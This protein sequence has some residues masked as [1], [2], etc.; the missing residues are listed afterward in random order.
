M[1][2]MCAVL[3]CVSIIATLSLAS[4]QSNSLLWKETNP[5]K[6]VGGALCYILNNWNNCPQKPA[7]SCATIPCTQ[8]IIGLWS[9]DKTTRDVRGIAGW[10]AGAGQV[11]GGDYD[12]NDVM[13]VYCAKELTCGPSCSKNSNG[14]RI[15]DQTKEVDKDA[16][17]GHYLIGNRCR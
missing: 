16:K 17:E 14:V 15:C 7:F 3:F 8:N 13:E 4:I 11:E 9:C 12:R 6:I 1:R 5:E 2:K 10:N